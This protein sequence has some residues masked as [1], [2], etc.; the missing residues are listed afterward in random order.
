MRSKT[1]FLLLKS[2]HKLPTD[3]AFLRLKQVVNQY[4]ADKQIF[5]PDKSNLLD[6]KLQLNGVNDV[7][8]SELQQCLIDSD[9][10]RY[11]PD[12]VQIDIKPLILRTVTVLEIIDREWRI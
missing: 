3:D 6:T 8:I 12:S 5:Y 10:G 11:L 7:T 1:L 4:L 2:A 9:A